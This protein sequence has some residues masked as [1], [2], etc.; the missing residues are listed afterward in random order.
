MSNYRD[1]VREMLKKFKTNSPSPES[2]PA[3]KSSGIEPATSE[4]EASE[5]E[6]TPKLTSAEKPDNSAEQD[7]NQKSVPADSETNIFDDILDLE[8]DGPTN[9]AVEAD[10][11][12]ENSESSNAVTKTNAKSPLEKDEEMEVDD[13]NGTTPEPIPDTSDSLN[14]NSDNDKENDKEKINEKTDIIEDSEKK[15]DNNG[16]EKTEEIKEIV[17]LDETIDKIDEKDEIEAEDI[18]EIEDKND[19]KELVESKDESSSSEAEIETIE[20]DIEVESESK[21]IKEIDDKEFIVSEVELQTEKEKFEDI[22]DLADDTNDSIIQPEVELNTG[23]KKAEEVDLVDDTND[24]EAMQ[25]EVEVQTGSKKTEEVDLV[26]DSNSI[27]ALDESTKNTPVDSADDD[28]TEKDENKP[29]AESEIEEITDEPETDQICSPRKEESKQPV[30]KKAG[31][32]PKTPKKSDDEHEVVELLSSNEE[33][34]EEDTGNGTT[35]DHKP[36]VK[37]YVVEEETSSEEEIDE[38]GDP[39]KEPGEGA[40]KEIT[41]DF[42]QPFHYG[43][44]RECVYRKS[45]N[46]S[47]TNC[48]VYYIPPQDGRY[49]TREAKR[50]RRSK[51]DQERYFEDFPDDDLSIKNFNYV[52]KPLGLGNAAYELIRQA[53]LQTAFEECETEREKEREK[54][55][56]MK[57]VEESAGLLESPPDSDDEEVKL[58]NGFDTIVPLSLQALAHI[59][60]MQNLHKCRRKIRDPETCCTPPLVEDSLWSNLVDDPVGV[61]TELG[62]RSSP[63]TPPPL[64]AVG[65]TYIA[66]AEKIMKAIQD[67]KDEAFKVD[68]TK[69]IDLIEDMATHDFAIKKFKNYK[70]TE[71]LDLDWEPEWKDKK[72]KPGRPSGTRGPRGPYN[73][74]KNLMSSS[75]MRPAM[76][77]PC[78]PKCPGSYGI[79]PSLQCVSCKAMFHAKCQG[80]GISDVRNF[81]CRRCSTK[82]SSQPARSQNQRSSGGYSD[83]NYAVGASASVKLKLPMMPKNGKRPIVE[84]VLRTPEGRY[85]PIKFRNNSQISEN[86]P[87]TLFHKANQAKK[88]LYVKSQQLPRLNGKPVFLAINPL[89]GAPGPGRPPSGSAP[90]GAQQPPTGDQVAILVRPQKAAANSKPVLLNVPRKVALKVKVGTTLSFSASNDH[91]YVVMDAKIH[92][93][94]G[95]RAP[96]R[97]PGRPPAQSPGL[98]KARLP[99]SLSV[100]PNSGSRRQQGGPR[101]NSLANLMGNKRPG[102]TITRGPMGGPTRPAKVAR[103]GSSRPPV[104]PSSSNILASGEV[105][106]ATQIAME[107]CTPYCPGVSGFPDLECTRCQSLFH[108]QCVG[109]NESLL[110]RIRST[111]KCRICTPVPAARPGPPKPK[112][113]PLGPRP[114]GG[115]VTVIN[116]D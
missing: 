42:L 62:G 10:N 109:I 47:V 23:S 13:N 25:P 112:P 17:E 14:E 81:R 9:E 58:I 45:K 114:G 22:V 20:P 69:E 55:K 27:E 63:V 50:K 111:F 41:E 99:S 43:W 82:G 61:F 83:Q 116:L 18:K 98:N 107:P 92:P 77:R 113:R 30:R 73:K 66:T 91:K 11:A 88:T 34:E 38:V 84:L 5:A 79:L 78:T 51:A 8:E 104:F 72:G 19:V 48:D 57:E 65:L 28:L 106:A 32:P 24:A 86:I 96:N 26:D 80:V 36:K 46:S 94:V 68:S 108:S 64:R 49:R 60:G 59:T 44:R 87:R 90:R 95:A 102:L 105:V 16:I 35:N 101:S 39:D 54:K 76:D 71:F 15:E 29:E 89:I 53:K 6:V 85:Q 40:E 7:K 52:R 103:P 1:D 2:T 31:R 21:Q 115:P 33:E 4:E 100:I 3:E 67:V 97:G 75:I 56:S 70:K 37:G 93:P 74:N 12:N 110:S